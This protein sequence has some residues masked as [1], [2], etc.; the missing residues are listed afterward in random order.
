MPSVIT[1]LFQ[2][3]ANFNCYEIFDFGVNIISFTILAYDSTETAQE[4]I[5]FIA[6]IKSRVH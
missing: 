6:D 2:F 3:P 4:E 5:W 1:T